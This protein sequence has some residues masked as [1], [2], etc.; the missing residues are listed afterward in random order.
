VQQNSL[1]IS[2]VVSLARTFIEDEKRRAPDSLKDI[3]IAVHGTWYYQCC[4]L[5]KTDIIFQIYTSE[6]NNHIPNGISLFCEKWWFQE[7]PAK[8]SLV[9]QTLSFLLVRALDTG[10]KIQDVLRLYAFRSALLLIDF[11]DER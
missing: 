11:Q 5:Y 4:G 9:P 10:G 3:G 7:R 8:E 2:A 6:P 1:F